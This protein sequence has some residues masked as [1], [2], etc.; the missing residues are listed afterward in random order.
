M[1]KNQTES[2][3]RAEQSVKQ[4]SVFARLYLKQLT[5]FEISR[6]VIAEEG[7]YTCRSWACWLGF[8]QKLGRGG[9]EKEIWICTIDANFQQIVITT[10]DEV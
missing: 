10:F 3:P 1:Y 9:E 7:Q 5:W 2:S 6:H 8:P 4:T